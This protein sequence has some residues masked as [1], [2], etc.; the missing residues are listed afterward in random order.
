[1]VGAVH[2]LAI[3]VDDDV[4]VQRLTAC[5]SLAD[6]LCADL[7]KSPLPVQG[8]DGAEAL[9]VLDGKVTQEEL[10]GIAASNLGAVDDVP[11]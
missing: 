9:Q 6:G 3:V 2:H 7:G 1:V 5:V 4:V 11:I 8:W 10:R